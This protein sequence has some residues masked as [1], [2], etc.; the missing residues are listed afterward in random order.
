MRRLA[1]L[2][3][4][5]ALAACGGSS[6]ASPPAAPGA[7]L[8]AHGQLSVA[9]QQRTYRVYRPGTVDPHTPA[10]LVLILHG[11]G[12]T[13]DE[14]VQ[15]TEFDNNADADGFIAV[16]PDG[17]ERSW[18]G[19][20]CCEPA[21]TLGIDDI[22]FLNALIPQL[23]R[24]FAI[25]SRRVFVTGFSSGAIMAYRFACQGTV[26]IAAIAPVAG[27]MLLTDDC[28]PRRPTS[29]LAINGTHDGEVPYQ[30]GHL[31]PGASASDAIVPSATSVT[32]RWAQLDSCGATPSSSTTGP[33]TVTQWHGC[34]GGAT[35]QLQTIT[36]AGHTWYAPGFGP[37]DGAIDA[38]KVIADFFARVR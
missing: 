38:S 25:D 22:A 29:V 3:P 36:G 10:P 16:Y 20:F 6:S 8:Q 11:N 7:P 31:L 30:G 34:A 35:V 19:G 9:G 17:V 37:A 32:S 28:H 4:L 15:T 27:T 26:P 14:M 24:S 23:E 18:N 2:V 12:S 13:G 21:P 1:A 33:V 5:A